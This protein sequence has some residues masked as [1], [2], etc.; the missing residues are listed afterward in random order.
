VSDLNG[1]RR[2]ANGR[3]NRESAVSRVTAS[4]CGQ[5]LVEHRGVAELCPSCSLPDF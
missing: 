1:N 4:F 3:R 2:Q 5:V